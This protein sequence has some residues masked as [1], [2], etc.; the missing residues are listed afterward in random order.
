MLSIVL[1]VS[2]HLRHRRLEAGL[3]LRRHAPARHAGLELVDDPLRHGARHAPRRGGATALGAVL[4]VVGFLAF[5]AAI[6]AA[7]VVGVALDGRR[8]HARHRGNVYFGMRML[9]H[10]LHGETPRLE[11]AARARGAAGPRG[12]VGW[13][14]ARRRGEPAARAAASPR[15]RA[16]SSALHAI[17]DTREA[18]LHLIERACA[19]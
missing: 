10:R 9:S 4:P 11:P 5:A 1:T 3:A 18:A 13:R 14:L 19:G 2:A 7:A 8:G 17:G 16:A 15:S 6:C 12:L